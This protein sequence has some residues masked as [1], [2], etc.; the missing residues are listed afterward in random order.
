M[1]KI[2]KALIHRAAVIC[3]KRERLCTLCD[4]K[5]CIYALSRVEKDIIEDFEHYEI[6]YSSYDAIRESLYNIAI[7]GCGA[8]FEKAVRGGDYF[9]RDIDRAKHYLEEISFQ[10]YKHFVDTNKD[11]P[12]DIY[13]IQ[14]KT[15]EGAFRKIW[16]QILIEL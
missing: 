1:K 10:I 12:F 5:P 14:A 6:D 15:L 16:D 9:E 8:D 4:T 7:H 11:E 2:T 13:R 3:R